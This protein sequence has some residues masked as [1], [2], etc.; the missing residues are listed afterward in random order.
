MK[1]AT[2]NKK[3][4]GKNITT[5]TTEL[6]APP[7]EVKVETTP[8]QTTS[9]PEAVTPKKR[10]RRHIPKKVLD[11]LD[12]SATQAV[13]TAHEKDK[14]KEQA[15]LPAVEKDALA[16][17]KAVQSIIK[18]AT[19]VDGLSPLGHK[20]ACQN[21]QLDVAILGGKGANFTE[22]LHSVCEANCES[23]RSDVEDNATFVKRLQSH[24]RFV[25]GTKQSGKVNFPKRLAKV[26][27]DKEAKAI[28]AAM[29]PVSKLF[30]EYVEAGK[31]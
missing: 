23:R 1:K 10:V 2:A 19:K 26:G 14:A 18:G 3:A 28:M 4:T 21:G 25:S 17:I 6:P 11:R 15:T 31:F 24:L 29:V 9:K 22:W 20:V 27:L 13:T 12:T 16:G 7:A 8:A 5:K 30:N